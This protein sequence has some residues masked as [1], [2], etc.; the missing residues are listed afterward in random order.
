MV[1]HRCL[2]EGCTR[3]LDARYLMC[4]VHWAMVPRDVQQ[5]VYAAYT[6]GQ[7]IATA[8]PAWHTAAD[9]AVAAVRT[10]VASKAVL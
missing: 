9:K 1:K 7:T 3:Q 6:A 5:E 4:G 8:S 2:A 10:A